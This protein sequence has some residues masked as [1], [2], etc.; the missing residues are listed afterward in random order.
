MNSSLENKSH[1][2]K[3]IKDKTNQRNWF[4]SSGNSH[5]IGKT[6][7]MKNLTEK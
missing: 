5:N 2:K 1:Q 3:S 7:N 6:S 4:Y